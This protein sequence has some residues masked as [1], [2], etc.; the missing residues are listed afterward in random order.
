M[1]GNVL[2]NVGVTHIKKSDVIPTIK[3]LGTLIQVP[4]TDLHIIGSAG[5]APYSGDIDVAID[6]NKFAPLKIH[7]RMLRIT[8]GQGVY[9][10]SFNMAS[11]AIPICGDDK[12]GKVQVDLIFT[13]NIEWT[14]F[15]YHSE[16]TNSKYKGAIRNILLS[17]VAA[18]KFEPD[19]NY[20]EY[21]EKGELLIRVGRTFDVNKGLRQVFQYRS[22][23]KR[24]NK[25]NK[26]L[27][28]ISFDEFQEKFPYISI[29]NAKTITKPT[30]A[31][32][33]LFNTGITIADVR[34]T[35]QV[36]TLIQDMFNIT[37]QN[38]IFEI[39][40]KRVKRINNKVQLPTEILEK[41]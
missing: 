20:L 6:S 15:S 19:I 25:Y 30:T 23:N 5:K 9:N 28:S 1:G 40:A 41:L 13:S 35:E 12:N 36:I 11:Y 17:A 27:K 8:N 38:K 24:T 16:G 4:V 26:I 37:R 31:V 34:T 2:K 39:A 18:T 29:V 3:Y 33:L 7:D 21:D 22:K 10:K 14:K 32:Q